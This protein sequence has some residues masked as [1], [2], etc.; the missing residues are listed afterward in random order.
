M[1]ENPRPHLKNQILASLPDEDY[2]RLAPHLKDVTLDHGKV[3]YE[4]G[5]GVEHVYFP[6]NAVVSLVTE[7]ADGK[8]VEVGLVGKDGMTGIT[9]LMGEETSPE[10]AIVQIA[11]GGVRAPFGDVKAEFN[12]GGEL[13]RLLLA[14]AQTDETGRS[15]GGL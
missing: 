13:Q 12:R 15:N 3:L 2:Q 9:A 6:T 1:H 8:I 11:N 5:E 7:M 14:Y 4:M 10:R